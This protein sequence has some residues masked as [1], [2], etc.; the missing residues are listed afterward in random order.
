MS[1]EIGNMPD[2]LT[3][4]YSRFAGMGESKTEIDIDIQYIQHS[5]E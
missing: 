5:I 2:W 3:Q 1:K 4:I